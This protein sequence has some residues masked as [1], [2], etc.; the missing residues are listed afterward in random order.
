MGNIC[1]CSSN[2]LLVYDRMPVKPKRPTDRRCSGKCAT[3]EARP[4][5]S[6]LKEPEKS[7]IEPKKQV[8]TENNSFVHEMDLIDVAES[9]EKDPLEKGKQTENDN[10]CKMKNIE[11]VTPQVGCFEEYSLFAAITEHFS[12]LGDF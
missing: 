3:D 4:P 12:L 11:W 1:A 9:S 8:S 6:K 7:A 10:L 5:V 2:S